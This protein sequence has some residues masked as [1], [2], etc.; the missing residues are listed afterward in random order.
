MDVSAIPERKEIPV[1]YTWDLTDIF[2]DDEAWASERAAL[3][4]IARIDRRYID[5]LEPCV[6]ERF[7][8]GPVPLEG[9][10]VVHATELLVVGKEVCQRNR[11]RTQPGCQ[12]RLAPRQRENGCHCDNIL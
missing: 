12:R 9:P 8:I 11:I 10:A 7:E 4:E 1:E 5:V 6:F 3:L 2:P